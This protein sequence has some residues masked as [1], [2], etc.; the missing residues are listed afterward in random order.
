ML[1]IENVIAVNPESS[2]KHLCERPYEM[3]EVTAAKKAKTFIPQ[4]GE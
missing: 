4:T 2:R 3:S 1:N